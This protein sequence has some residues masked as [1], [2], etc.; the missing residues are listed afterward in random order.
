MDGK[1]QPGGYGE[2]VGECQLHKVRTWNIKFS[3]YILQVS[4]SDWPDLL[5]RMNDMALESS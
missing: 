5:L 3:A 2:D 4:S 1:D